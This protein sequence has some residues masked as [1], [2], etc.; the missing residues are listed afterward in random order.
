MSLFAK[1]FH[2]VILTSSKYNIDESHGLKHSMEVFQFA[3]KIY[4]QE[5]AKN[6]LLES[7]TRIIYASAIVHDMCDKKYMN[8]KKAIR[9]LDN[10]L[11][12]ELSQHEI[13][14]VKEI[15][16]TMSY[17]KVKVNGFPH[18]GPYMTAYHVV[19]EADLLAAYDFDRCMI[20]QMHNA[21]SDVE[22]AFDNASTL[23]ENRVLKHNEHGLF[24]TDYAKEISPV[25]HEQ[26]IQRIHSWRRILLH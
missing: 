4:E 8:E 11:E 21:N 9:E 24:T 2:F 15:V 20:Y 26:A 5:V 3:H 16:S 18:L 19:R 22:E 25:L 7:Q 12:P 17:S 6:V 13:S 14:I 1:L 23:F 10:I